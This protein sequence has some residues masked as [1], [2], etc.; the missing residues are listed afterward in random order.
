MIDFALSL[1]DGR[2]VVALAAGDSLPANVYY[3]LHVKRGSWFASPAFGSRL[4]EVGGITADAI[5]LA[6]DYCREALAWLLETGRAVA[7]EALVERDLQDPTRFAIAV[8]VTRSNG[9]VVPLN[10]FYSVV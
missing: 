1:V 10:T 9:E 2:P 7:V 8:K 4:H 6:G 3:S 5:S